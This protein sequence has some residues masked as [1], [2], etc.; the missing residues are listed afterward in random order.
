[1]V[2]ETTGNI[3]HSFMM[4]EYISKEVALEQMSKVGS[5][6]RES[7]RRKFRQNHTPTRVIVR[8]GVARLIRDGIN[9]YGIRVSHSDG[10]SANGAENMYNFIQSALMEKTGTL[11]VGGAFPRH[12]P[13]KRRNGKVIG[14]MGTL[15][16]VS[17]RAVSILHR[18]DTGEENS[19]YDKKTKLT[20]DFTPRGFMGKGI[21]AAQSQIQSRLEDGFISVMENAQANNQVKKT[22]RK[23]A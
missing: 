10:G 8:K 14:T 6:V 22:D 9:P 4:L 16:A 7:I 15:N 3:K 19:Y 23:L 18:M 12:R 13:K 5:D 2:V 20:D 11:V 17:Q 1:M 21:R